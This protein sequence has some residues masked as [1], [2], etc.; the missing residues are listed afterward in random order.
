MVAR[1][2][3]NFGS[4]FLCGLIAVTNAPIGT[5]SSA[6]DRFPRTLYSGVSFNRRLYNLRWVKTASW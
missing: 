4:K 6:D 5:N 1:S 3:S 2:G